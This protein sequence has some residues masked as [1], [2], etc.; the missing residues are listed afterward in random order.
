LQG[1]VG[2][3]DGGGRQVED[4]AQGA[5]SSLQRRG[6]GLRV[7]QR[8]ARGASVEISDLA[9]A[10]LE[11]VLERAPRLGARRVDAREGGQAPRL[12][13][14]PPRLVGRRAVPQGVED[15]EDRRDHGVLVRV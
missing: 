11:R 3:Y 9:A 10:A 15:G 8:R 6:D 13:L 14:L 2:A 7:R 5:S 12:D 4:R 1:L